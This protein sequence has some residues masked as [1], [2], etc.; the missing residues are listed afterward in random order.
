MQ[1]E[2]DVEEDGEKVDA[3]KSVCSNGRRRD[4]KTEENREVAK[5]RG[6]DGERML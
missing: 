6:G 1:Q 5:R 3:V 4:R 2:L